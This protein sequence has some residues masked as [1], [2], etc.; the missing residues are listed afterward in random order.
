M[1]ISRFWRGISVSVYFR[2]LS[3]LNGTS[4]SEPH[5]FTEKLESRIAAAPNAGY[6]FGPMT[7]RCVKSCHDGIPENR[8]RRLQRGLRQWV[9]PLRDCCCSSNSARWWRYLFAIPRLD[10]ICCRGCRRILRLGL[11]PLEEGEAGMR[12]GRRA[13][14]LLRHRPAK[15]TERCIAKKNYLRR[16]L[17]RCPSGNRTVLNIFRASSR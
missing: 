8:Q 14:T 9:W 1:V 17:G 13:G 5:P 3:Q 15:I 16:V 4:R 10:C 2:L 11:A 6:C 7:A 12:S